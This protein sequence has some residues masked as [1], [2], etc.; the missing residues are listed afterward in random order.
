MLKESKNIEFKKE[1]PVTF[2]KTVSAF[3]SY[4]TGKIVYKEE[5][6]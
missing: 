3:V 4:G 1:I 5:Q 6:E 2:L